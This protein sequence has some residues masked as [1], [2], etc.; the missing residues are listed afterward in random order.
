MV[1]AALLG[2][3]RPSVA[4]P[5]GGR[6]SPQEAAAVDAASRA[7][8]EGHLEEA[9]SALEQ[10]Y[11][12]GGDAELLFRLGELTSRMGQD[13]RALRLYRTYLSRGPGGK[14]RAAAER[15]IG[16]LQARTQ[17]AGGAS[18]P[19]VT[20]TGAGTTGSANAAGGAPSTST[21]PATPP[22]AMPDSAAAVLASAPPAGPPALTA[23]STPPPEPPTPRWLPWAGL[24][25]TVGLAVA[26]TIS[27]LSASNRYDQ[28]H[29]SCGAT[30]AGCSQA[31]IDDVRSSANLTTALWVGAGVMAAATG[32]GFYANTHEAGFS[33]VWK[34]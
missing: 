14:N 32:A 5:P 19:P 26:A 10:A 30:V 34:F 21:A 7:E 33:G 2:W 23:A 27:G 22:A 18:P 9:A 3:A 25:A 13:V 6:G 4:I 12:A 24:T 29:G 11:Q 15:A 31:Q 20:T 17:A 1:F 8:A 28:L 16:V